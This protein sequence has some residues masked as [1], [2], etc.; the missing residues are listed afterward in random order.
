MRL[1][2]I[3]STFEAINAAIDPSDVVAQYDFTQ[4][5]CHAGL[6]ENV[7]EDGVFGDLILDDSV[8][9][10]DGV[11]VE[12]NLSKGSPT[13]Y[14]TGTNRAFRDALQ[15]PEE[16]PGFT[17]ELWVTLENKSCDAY[18]DGSSNCVYSLFAIHNPNLNDSSEDCKHNTDFQLNYHSD[19]K[20]FEARFRNLEKGCVSFETPVDIM[21]YNTLGY[22]FQFVFSSKEL[23]SVSRVYGVLEF[24][25]NA[26]RVRMSL[27][28][29]VLSD[30]I[31]PAW[32]E[33]YTAQFLDH[34]RWPSSTEFEVRR[35]KLHSAKIY[36]TSIAKTTVPTIYAKGIANSTPVAYDVAIKINEDGEAGDHYEDPA[37]YLQPFPVTELKII[38]MKVYDSD[39]DPTTPNY[40]NDARPKAF[41]EVLPHTGQLIDAAGEDITTTPF[42]VYEEGGVFP[43]RY[44]PLF[45]EYSSSVYT[46][47]SFYAEDGVTGIRSFT[48]A[49]V[50]IYVTPK[51]D[52]PVAFNLNLDAYAGTHENIVQLRGSDVDDSDEVQGAEIVESP[53]NGKLYQ[54]WRNACQQHRA[55]RTKLK[56]FHP[57]DV[58][59]FLSKYVDLHV[60]LR[61]LNIL[62]CHKILPSFTNTSR[63]PTMKPR[64]Q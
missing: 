43:V 42:E 14:S 48:S 33:D 17:V 28:N 29:A 35:A 41:V 5:E 27:G 30:A 11:G 15:E 26:T 44:R 6:V 25:I 57:H 54:V 4:A 36:L 53:S 46:S 3:L 50:T 19:S 62:I 56:T 16:Y 51:N 52:P 38:N 49:T 37:A 64:Y 58:V 24:Y 10:L 1:A 40:R 20:N 8:S 34:R 9:C 59:F 23:Q 60:I 31:L 18:S 39:N 7:V 55:R 13:A 63:D 22:P 47:F 32:H 21:T 12:S 61:M 2:Y 45:N